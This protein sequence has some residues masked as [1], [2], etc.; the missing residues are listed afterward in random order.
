MKQ[1]QT[2]E[3]RPIGV[4]RSSYMHRGDA[5]RQ[6]REKPDIEMNIE[7]FEP[8]QKGL[9]S[10]DGIS[11]VIILLWFDRANRDRLHSKPPLA[12]TE[13]PVFTTRSP[14]RP[15]PIGFEIGRLISIKP[16]ALRVSGLDALDGTPVVDIKPYVPSLDCVP[17][18]EKSGI[19]PE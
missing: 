5:P 11:H 14:H 4:V 19:T 1:Q 10:F 8:F 15:N 2:F 13:R 7:I 18:A 12:K 17:N 6:G 9:G 3:V 16:G